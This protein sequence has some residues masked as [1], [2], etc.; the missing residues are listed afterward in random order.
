VRL[1][2]IGL[3]GFSYSFKSLGNIPFHGLK[4][5]MPP[6]KCSRDTGIALLSSVF[7]RQAILQGCCHFKPLFLFAEMSKRCSGQSIERFSTIKTTHSL[8]SALSSP[9]HHIAR[10]AVQALS[11][12]KKPVVEEHGNLLEVI[13]LIKNLFERCSLFV[14]EVVNQC[15][16]R[17]ECFVFHTASFLEQYGA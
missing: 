8:K 4:K 17:L 3:V 5:T 14:C 11:L 7:H 9:F 12:R 6:P 15:K 13:I 2:K 1:K 10:F 16:Q